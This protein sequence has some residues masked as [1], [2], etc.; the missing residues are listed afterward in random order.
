MVLSEDKSLRMHCSIENR[1]TPDDKLNVKLLVII[2]DTSTQFPE[3]IFFLA[4]DVDF[5]AWFKP[6]LCQKRN[7]GA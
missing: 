3:I 5:A 4:K 6:Q 7:S 2:E 1:W